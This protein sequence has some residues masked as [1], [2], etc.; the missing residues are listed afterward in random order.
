MRPATAKLKT[1]ERLAITARSLRPLLPTIS[2]QLSPTYGSTSQKQ[3]RTR[4]PKE[5]QASVRRSES[6]DSVS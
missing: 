4:Q 5:P 1:A 3:R 2:S 6:E